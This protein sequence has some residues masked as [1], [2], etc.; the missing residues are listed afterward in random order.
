MYV[1]LAFLLLL[2]GRFKALQTLLRGNRLRLFQI[3]G[4]AIDGFARTL[5]G[6]DVLADFSGLRVLAHRNLIDARQPIRRVKTRPTNHRC[7]KA[8]LDPPQTKHNK[9]KTSTASK[10]GHE[11]THERKKKI[12]R[13]V[14]W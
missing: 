12:T 7:C 10:Q 11:N 1:L 3:R 6:D 9:T 2:D 14:D 8:G 13:K 4:R 5:H